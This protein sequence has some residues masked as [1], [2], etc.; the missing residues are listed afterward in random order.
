[1]PRLAANIGMIFN[2]YPFLDRFEHAAKAGFKAVEYMSPYEYDVHELK[3]YLDE[4]KLQH[5]LFN[6]P[7]GDLANGERGT[8][9]IKG[10]DDEFKAGVEKC[11][12]YASILGASCINCCVGRTTESKEEVIERLIPRIKF[13]ADTLAKHNVK[14]ALE[15]LN[16]F[17]VTNFFFKN[18]Q[19]IADFVE[20]IKHENVFLLYD[21]Y[22]AQ[23]MEGELTN[24]LKKYLPIVPHIQISDNPGRHEPGTGEINYKNILKTIDDI[25]YKGWVGLEYMPIGKSEDS[26]GWIKEYGLSL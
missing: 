5:I 24:N 22:H 16:G 26:F 3:R 7:M 23:R 2:E 8:A 13:A 20:M 19:E 9:V 15:A 1:M 6:L 21:V 4:F 14:L 10:R 17:D 18:N 12:E 25:G 11:A